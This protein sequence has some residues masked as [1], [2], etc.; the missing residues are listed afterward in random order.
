MKKIGSVFISKILGL[1]KKLVKTISDPMG[2]KSDLFRILERIEN[3]PAK[4]HDIKIKFTSETIHKGLEKMGYEG[5]ASNR[6]IKIEFCPKNEKRFLIKAQVYPKTVQIDVACTNNPIIFDVPSLFFLHE[7]LSDF[8]NHL[9][10]ISG[11]F[12]PRVKEWEITHFHLNK[13]G[14]FEVNG[15]RF[16]MT[17]GDASEG[18]VR[19]YSKVMPD[20]KILPRIEKVQ[21]PKTTLEQAMIKSIG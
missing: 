8:S 15:P 14:D 16:H 5:L 6:G 13:D 20:G 1:S 2:V 12:A 18:L 11:E 3:Q 19:Y 21:T 7:I 10:E 4:I 9:Y 17:I